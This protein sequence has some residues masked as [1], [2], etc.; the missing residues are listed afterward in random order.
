MVEQQRQEQQSSRETTRRSETTERQAEE[1]T[2][3]AR[4][5]DGEAARQI[6][7]WQNNG[8]VVSR[9]GCSM[10]RLAGPVVFL[11]EVIAANPVHRKS[12]GNSSV[13]EGRR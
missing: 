5:S 4:G 12:M 13:P 9:G 11:P 3:A 1:A 10:N 6:A 8:V 7:M 2:E